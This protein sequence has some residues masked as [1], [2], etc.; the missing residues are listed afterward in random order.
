MLQGNNGHVGRRPVTYETKEVHEGFREFVRTNNRDGYN[1][2]SGLSVPIRELGLRN[3]HCGSYDRKHISRNS[4]QEGQDDLH[5]QCNG[6]KCRG[7][8]RGYREA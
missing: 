8:V 3:L 6:I 7:D 4:Y 1:S 5:V 2:A